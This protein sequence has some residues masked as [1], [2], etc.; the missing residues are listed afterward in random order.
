MKWK[1]II[2]GT[3]AA[4]L[5]LSSVITAVP[6]EAIA[7]DNLVTAEISGVGQQPPSEILVSEDTSLKGWGNEPTTSHGD[8]WVLTMGNERCKD[9][10]NTSGA[11]AEQELKATSNVDSKI[12]LLKFSIPESLKNN[13]DSI[14]SAKL[15][16]ALA[17]FRS[18]G[19]MFGAQ[20][21]TDKLRVANVSPLEWTEA[22]ATR[23][24]VRD[25][26]YQQNNNAIPEFTPYKESAEYMLE[27]GVNDIGPYTN[28]TKNTAV[29]GEIV[30]TDITDLLADALTENT[31]EITLAVNESSKREHYFVSKEGVENL[32]NATENMMP[33]IVLT[34]NV[35]RGKTVTA[36]LTFTDPGLA[37]DGNDSAHTGSNS[38]DAWQ[39]AELIDGNGAELSE[40]GRAHV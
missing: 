24:S 29:S 23:N 6:I 40:I 34:Y 14:K 26:F 20:G 12:T 9:N 4:V 5:V 15:S 22:T 10:P 19:G 21:D 8:Q 11:F 30:E 7:A 3:L 33:K 16:L 2:S 37:V 28:G 17:G 31:S 13:K 18:S 25:W 1:K 39:S 27:N 32:D 35:A 38:N 36:S